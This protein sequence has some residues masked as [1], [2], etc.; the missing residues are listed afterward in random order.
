MITSFSGKYDF[1]SNFF[2]SPIKY[3]GEEWPTAEHLFQGLK[4]TDPEE[5]EKVRNCK[6]PGAAKRLGRKVTLRPNWNAER[7][8]VM[9]TVLRWKFENFAL[10][11]MLIDTY[12]EELVEGN[13]WNDTF[14]GV[15]RG[16]G[17]N[18]LGKLLM[19]LREEFMK[20][21]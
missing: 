19:K 2:Y 17:E 3:N 13:T 15:C 11:L 8:Q 14:W 4:T 18:N 5:R 20:L 7:V 21:S 10:R 16:R 1:L 9:E 12:P 6:T